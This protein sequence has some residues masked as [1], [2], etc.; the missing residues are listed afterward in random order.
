M[1]VPRINEFISASELRVI[2]AEGKLIGEI[3]RDQ[4]LLLAFDQGLDLVLVDPAAQPPVA[5]LVDYGKFSYQEAKRTK[6]AKQGKRS[7]LKQIRLSARIEPHD[8]EMKV[9]RA[10]QF[11]KLGHKVLLTVRMRGRELIFSEN[12]KDMLYRFELSSGGKFESQPKRL[13]KNW[14][15]VIVKP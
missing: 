12:I 14:Q 15:A 1:A 8:F 7:E 9:Q 5:K 3:S 13:G 10:R 11:L 6:G 2:D 4:A